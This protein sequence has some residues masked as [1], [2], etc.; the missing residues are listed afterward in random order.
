MH[1]DT[2]KEGITVEYSQAKIEPDRDYILKRT[3]ML[4]GSFLYYEDYTDLNKIKLQLE[5]TNKKLEKNNRLLKKQSNVKAELASLAAEKVVYE[6]IDNI[7]KKDTPKVESLLKEMNNVAQASNLVGRI[8]ILV[9][10]IKR[11]CILRVNTLYKKYQSVETFLGYIGEMQ[12]FTKGLPLRITVGCRYF[13]DFSIS[14]AMLICKVV[15]EAA[16]NGCSDILVQ[17]YEEN[18]EIIFSVIPDEKITLSSQVFEMQADLDRMGGRLSIKEGYDASA[19]LLCFKK[20][21]G[22]A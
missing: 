3:E 16:I 18:G 10:G 12:E 1:G 17:V 8:N 13:G 5:E 7:I 11:K 22:T 2:N 6:S 4:S 20:D 9:C 15:E 21:E 14:Y 19:V